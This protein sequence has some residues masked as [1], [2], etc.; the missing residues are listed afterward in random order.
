MCGASGTRPAGPCCSTTSPRSLAI[1]AMCSAMSRQAA[2]VSQ[3][4]P[5][6][7]DACARPGFPCAFPG[8]PPP[9]V[10]FRFASIRRWR[11]RCAA[12]RRKRLHHRASAACSWP[13][14]RS[15]VRC[16]RRSQNARLGVSSLSVT[17]TKHAE[18]VLRL[19]RQL[20][21]RTRGG[22]ADTSAGKTAAGEPNPPLPARAAIVNGN[23]WHLGRA[24][25]SGC[26][27][28][29]LQQRGPTPRNLPAACV[30]RGVM[31]ATRR[32]GAGVW[33]A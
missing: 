33:Q 22:K 7:D 4:G 26:A 6:Q 23:C 31:M 3:L 14:G 15:G 25:I 9:R 12:R 5:M 1:V 20:W 32:A 13:W 10:G 17:G 30:H 16:A 18:D 11:T 24:G 2:S 28:A 8:S 19:R 21:R 29:R 27:R